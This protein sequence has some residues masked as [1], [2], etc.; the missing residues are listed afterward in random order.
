MKASSVNMDSLSRTLCLSYP[1]RNARN[2][3]NKAPESC[4]NE[5]LNYCPTWSFINTTVLAF[6]M[7]VNPLRDTSH[8]RIKPHCLKAGFHLRISIGIRRHTQTHLDVDNYHFLL[9][10][11]LIKGANYQHR[12]FYRFFSS[13]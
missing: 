6:S 3:S 8:S 13:A 4:L 11:S 10:I 1:V 7:G 5:A 9:E 12:F 2:M